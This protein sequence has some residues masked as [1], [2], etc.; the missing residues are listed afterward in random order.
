MMD[1][2]MLARTAVVLL[3]VLMSLGLFGSAAASPTRGRGKG[4]I[5]RLCCVRNCVRHLHIPDGLLWLR[6]AKAACKVAAIHQSILGVYSLL[7][8]Y[9]G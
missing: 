7:T 4:G 2:A 3:C 8:I 1:F 9:V 5:I 6:F